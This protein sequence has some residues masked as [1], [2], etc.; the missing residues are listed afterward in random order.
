M[1]RA[2]EKI[3]NDR[4]HLFLLLGGLLLGRLLG[5]LGLLLRSHGFNSSI[6]RPGPSDSVP[7]PKNANNMKYLHFE[8]QL[9]LDI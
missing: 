5:L 3:L 8:M 9:C 1:I 2:P 7:P 6:V 4:S